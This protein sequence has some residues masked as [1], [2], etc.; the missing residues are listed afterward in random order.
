MSTLSQ[1]KR[2]LEV[3][4]MRD[5]LAEFY[6]DWVNQSIREICQD[7]SFNCMRH[8]AQVTIPASSSSVALPNDFKELTPA[9]TPIHLVGTDGKLSPVDVT[10]REDIIKIRATYLSPIATS[11]TGSIDV[12]LSSDADGW[13]LNLL[14][15]TT[16]AATFA[17]S[18]FRILPAIEAETDGNYL[19]RTYEDMVK[20]KL[21]A[22]AFA[23]V[24]DPIAAS[25][26]AKYELAKRRAVG[27]DARRWAKGRKTQ[28][29]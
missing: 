19:T 29:G 7:A 17:V 16:T 8:L 6:K 5:D 20:S 11:L 26:E 22:I 14:D 10:R 23:E 9:R 13:T 1:L 18:Y 21:R 25:W 24:N 15:A 12:Y 4:V 2:V 28:M 27:D 3:S